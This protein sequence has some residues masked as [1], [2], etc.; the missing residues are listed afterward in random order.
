MLLAPTQQLYVVRDETDQIECVDLLTTETSSIVG[1]Y[2]GDSLLLSYLIPHDNVQRKFLVKFASTVTQTGRQHCEECVRLLSHSIKVT[3]F[4][5]TSTSAAN[6]NSNSILST[7]EMIKVLMNESP[8]N[9]STYYHQEMA[10]DRHRK[11]AFIEKCLL[12]ETFPDF[13][14][15]VASI[16]DTMKDATK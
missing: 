8:A 5:S 15:T 10:F 6:D 13:V 9:L 11:D 7:A 1:T 16:L 12:D 14:A 3:H 2:S 4:D